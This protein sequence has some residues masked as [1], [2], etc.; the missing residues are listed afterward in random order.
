MKPAKLAAIRDRVAAV[1]AEIRATAHTYGAPCVMI[2]CRSAKEAEL[3][4][5]F[6]RSARADIAALLTELGEPVEPV[7]EAM[8]LV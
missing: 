2:S 6:V 5:A 3:I 1:P 7:Q 4:A 8:E